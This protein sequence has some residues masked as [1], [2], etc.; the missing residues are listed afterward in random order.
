MHVNLFK[1]L[2]HVPFHK[3]EISAEACDAGFELTES[4]EMGGGCRVPCVHAMIS[5]QSNF[6][7]HVHWACK[8]NCFQLFLH[9]ACSYPVWSYFF[10]AAPVGY[11]TRTFAARC[12]AFPDNPFALNHRCSNC[13]KSWVMNVVSGKVHC[14]MRKKNGRR[15]ISWSWHLASLGNWIDLIGFAQVVRCQ[16]L[17]GEQ[18]HWPSFASVLHPGRPWTASLPRTHG[19]PDV[20]GSLWRTYSNL[21]FR[22]CQSRVNKRMQIEGFGFICMLREF[23]R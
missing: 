14:T 13:S 1:A 20:D 18:F 19:W 2:S 6:C 16:H 10:V 7:L 12:G 21:L 22:F 17:A 8:T 15:M 11:S 4:T 23:I 9:Y 3:S 5:L